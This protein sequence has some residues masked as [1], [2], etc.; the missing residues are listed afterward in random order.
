M[1]EM[2]HRHFGVYGVCVRD[3][4]LLVIRKTKGPYAGRFDLPGGTVE[5]S[6]SLLVALVREFSEETG[7]V[8]EPIRTIGAKDFVLPWR[9]E[10]FDHTHCHHIAVFYETAWVGGEPEAAAGFDDSGGAAWVELARLHDDEVSPL[11]MTAIDWLR[12]GVWDMRTRM[13][14]TWTVAGTLSQANWRSTNQNE[15]KSV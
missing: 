14:D 2:W 10:G 12:G 6:E 8:I 9:R 5:P 15:P 7:S 13:Y 1:E 4:R 11:V 3:Q